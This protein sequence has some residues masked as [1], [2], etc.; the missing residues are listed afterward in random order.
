MC[1][2]G[3]TGPALHH[4]SLPLPPAPDLSHKAKTAKKQLL[5]DLQ[6]LQVRRRR[7]WLAW[8]WDC[9][10]S[11]RAAGLRRTTC[12]LLLACSSLILNRLACCLACLPQEP[13]LHTTGIFVSAGRHGGAAGAPAGPAR[14]QHGVLR[15][16]CIDSLD[17]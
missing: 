13:V 6:R 7:Q 15:T 14:E 16:N 12:C 3:D 1:V 2:L 5:T 8:N 11:L 17:R 4:R 10:R 9:R